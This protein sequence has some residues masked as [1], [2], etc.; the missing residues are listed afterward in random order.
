MESKNS[1]NHEYF[2]CRSF[3]LPFTKPHGIEFLKG[4]GEHAMQAWC[5]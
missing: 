4:A 3:R 5:L 2:L 1:L